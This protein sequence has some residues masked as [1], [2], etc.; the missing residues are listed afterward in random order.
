RGLSKAIDIGVVGKYVEL[1]DAY[2][3]VVESLKH[4][5]YSYDA[6]IRIHWINSEKLEAESIQKELSHVD[7]IIV[8]GV[9]GDRG[10]EGKIEA[11]RYAREKE[12]PFFGI[13]LGMQLASVEFARNVLGLEH[14]HSQEINPDTEHPIIGLLPDQENVADM[15]GTLRLGVY[16]CALKDGSKTKHV[17]NNEDVIH[18]RHR[19]RYEFNNAYR[20]QFEENGMTFS[21]MSP[22]GKLVEII[23]LNDHPWFVACQFHPEFKSRT[24]KPH[25]LF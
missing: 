4:A 25:A 3:S 8:P 10:I 2:L 16:P 20:K 13:C 5:G 18:E 1:P 22:D 17:Y 21:G 15:G 11:I 24:I 6:D 19:H 12:I 7:G 9:F 23:E 14:A